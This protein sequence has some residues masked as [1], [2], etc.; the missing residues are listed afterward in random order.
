MSSTRDYLNTRIHD[1]NKP[2]IE[3]S[4]ETDR[5]LANDITGE[6]YNLNAGYLLLILRVA[7]EYCFIKTRGIP[8]YMSKDCPEYFF[9]LIE[10]LSM[11]I[12]LC[13]PKF[14]QKKEILIDLDAKLKKLL[15]NIDLSF[16]S[17]SNG[18]YINP[19][20]LFQLKLDMGSLFRD[21]FNKMEEL[22]MLTFIKDNPNFA[23][24][25]YGD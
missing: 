23:M 12:D 3:R 21:I 25:K 20:H 18:I 10:R 2:N 13:S 19:R 17:K 4:I 16:Q 1:I 15:E 24:G 11:M 5:N 22:G 9:E 14:K 8:P 7:D 6:V